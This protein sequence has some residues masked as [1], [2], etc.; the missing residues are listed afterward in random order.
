MVMDENGGIL[1]PSDPPSTLPAW[2]DDD[3]HHA[4]PDHP[5]AYI[6]CALKNRERLVDKVKQNVPLACV[7]RRGKIPLLP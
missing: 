7:K 6:K 5:F 3:W 1:L 2:N 4:N